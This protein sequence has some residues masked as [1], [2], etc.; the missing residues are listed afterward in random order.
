MIWELGERRRRSFGSP[1]Q[2]SCWEEEE[3]LCGWR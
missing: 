2:T 3:E 1:E